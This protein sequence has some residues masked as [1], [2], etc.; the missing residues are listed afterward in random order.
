[1]KKLLMVV[2]AVLIALVATALVLPDRV[3]VERS[4]SITRPATTVFTLLDGFA[5]WT[6]WSPWVT[7]DESVRVARSG[8]ERGPGA[9][10][11]WSGDPSKAGLGSQ[12]IIA[13]DAPARIRLLMTQG[14]QAEALL[15]YVI[16]GDALGSRLT[17]IFESEVTTGNGFRDRLIGRYYGWFLVRWVASDFERGLA[18]FKA[19]AESLPGADFSRAE[20]TQVQVAPLAVVRVTNL[21]AATAEGVAEAVADAFGAISSWA[22]RHDVEFQG[23]PFIITHHAASGVQYYEA[24]VPIGR[25]ALAPEEGGVTYGETPS[26]QAVCLLHRGSTLETLA[27]YE[28]LDAWIMAHGLE[29][30]GVSWEHYLSDPSITADGSTSL[31]IC[32]MIEAGAP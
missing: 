15:E 8:P 24:A 3:V 22:L 31:E 9:R 29:T 20:I 16:D 1:V 13:S 19:H 21:R 14:A 25:D 2:G 23:Q 28:Q 12:E 11:D 27:S 10:I 26:G 6:E 4:I 5:S 18:R 7:R 17:W 32:V 30:A